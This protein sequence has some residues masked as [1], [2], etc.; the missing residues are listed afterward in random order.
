[1]QLRMQNAET[2]NPDHIS[3]FL[4][5]SGGIECV[6]QSRCEIYAWVQRALVAQEYAR[7]AR[8]QRGAIRAY[9][10]KI[11]GLSVPQT[12]RL[13]AMY[14]ERG[15]RWRRKKGPLWQVEGGQQC[16]YAMDFGSAFR[17]RSRQPFVSG[18]PR[19]CHTATLVA[20]RQLHDLL[21]PS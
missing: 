4:K 7:Q 20:P 14:L 1:M 21:V 12:A 19:G 2:L 3:E 5:L 17:S 11:T 10:S 9:L 6:S 18:T 15:C 8:K 13:I 16:G